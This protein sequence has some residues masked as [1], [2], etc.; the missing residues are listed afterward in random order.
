MNPH[1]CQMS[2]APSLQSYLLV[3]SDPLKKVSNPHAY[4]FR[5]VVWRELRSMQFYSLWTR[6]KLVCSQRKAGWLPVE[7]GVSIPGYHR[8]FLVQ[9]LVV[10]FFVKIQFI[11]F[12]LLI[13]S[14]LSSSCLVLC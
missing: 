12:I 14:Y 4:A 3:R 9:L 10:Q 13:L 1:T 7:L 11:I 2:N 6:L 5:L 8:L